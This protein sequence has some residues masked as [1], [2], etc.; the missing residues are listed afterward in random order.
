MYVHTKV[1]QVALRG[2]GNTFIGWWEPA[3]R[4]DFAYL[5]FK[6]FSKLKQHFV[7]TEHQSKS[8]LT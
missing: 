1:F 6:N 8:K 5:I 3:G 7:N 2:G 4:S